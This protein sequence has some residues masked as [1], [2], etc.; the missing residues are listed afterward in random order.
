M[1]AAFA[2]SAIS[3]PHGLR[4]IHVAR[5]FHV[6]R[7]PHRRVEALSQHSAALRRDDL[8]VDVPRRAMYGQ[9]RRAELA[10]LTRVCAARR[11]RASFLSFI[12]SSPTSSSP[13]FTLICSPA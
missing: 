11:M 5:A 4:R 3:A 12:A 8:R 6:V 1:P 9:A 2:R 7:T 13:S 10:H